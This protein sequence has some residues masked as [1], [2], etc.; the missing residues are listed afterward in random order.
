MLLVHSPRVMSDTI[1]QPSP[2]CPGAWIM[3]QNN[4]QHNHALLIW[5]SRW[6]ET[7]FPYLVYSINFGVFIYCLVVITMWVCPTGYQRLSGA[8]GWVSHCNWQVVEVQKVLAVLK[9]FVKI[10]RSTLW[11]GGRTRSTYDH[12]ASQD[13][14]WIICIALVEE[15]PKTKWN[16]A[17]SWQKNTRWESQFWS[18]RFGVTRC[19]ICSNLCAI[20]KVGLFHLSYHKVLQTLICI[21]SLRMVWWW[22]NGISSGPGLEAGSSLGWGRGWDRKATA[23]MHLSRSEEQ[24]DP[25]I[26]F[27]WEW[28]ACFWRNEIWNLTWKA[29]TFGVRT[30]SIEACFHVCHLRPSL[31]TSVFKRGEIYPN[32]LWMQ[33]FLL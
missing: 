25:V 4:S 11:Q 22:S 18:Q 27:C 14:R 6:N 24:R 29:L 21:I 12:E 5:V 28:V 17:T 1:K 2:L 15:I 8:T 26:R 10:F 13:K 19:S 30:L 32:C 23:G 20:W 33:S 31:L 7:C 9:W 3:P 16:E